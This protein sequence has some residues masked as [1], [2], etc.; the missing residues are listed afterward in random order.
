MSVP[1]KSQIV[2]FMLIF[3]FNKLPHSSELCSENR[4]GKSFNKHKGGSESMTTHKRKM[5]ADCFYA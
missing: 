3:V 1:Y 4:R 2:V 5:I